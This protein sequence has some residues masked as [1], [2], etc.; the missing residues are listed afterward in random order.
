MTVCQIRCANCND[1]IFVRICDVLG[2]CQYAYYNHSIN[3]QWVSFQ[4][5]PPVLSRKGTRSRPNR[6]IPKF[7]HPAFDRPVKRRE[8]EE[9]TIIRE[10]HTDQADPLMEVDAIKSEPLDLMDDTIDI[11]DN[12]I[13]YDQQ[14]FSLPE[15]GHE[16]DTLAS[17]SYPSRLRGIKKIKKERNS[18]ILEPPVITSDSVKIVDVADF[19]DSVE[20]NILLSEDPLNFS[21]NSSSKY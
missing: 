8:L 21:P 19:R 1:F 17:P 16:T 14:E 18:P 12:V 3:L 9:S 6:K 7:Y 11:E 15:M 4:S 2:L 20:N 13:Q 10:P 5:P